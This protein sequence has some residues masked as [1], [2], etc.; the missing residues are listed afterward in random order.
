MIYYNDLIMN[1][2]NRSSV[3][4]I[5]FTGLVQTTRLQLFAITF[6]LNFEIVLER[7]K[8]REEIKA[9]IFL[10]QATTFYKMAK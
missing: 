6:E 9:V 3:I 2:Y 10:Y 5:L 7:N 8:K 1:G 4:S